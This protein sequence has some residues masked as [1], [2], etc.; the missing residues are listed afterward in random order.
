MR[1]LG[2]DG[3]GIGNN[4]LLTV[5]WVEH[6][7]FPGAA[8]LR[9]VK[10]KV[11]YLAKFHSVTRERRGESNLDIVQADICDE[12]GKVLDV[13]YEDIPTDGNSRFDGE[14]LEDAVVEVMKRKLTE[15]AR[16][17]VIRE[18]D[19]ELVV[20]N[21]ATNFIVATFHYR[22]RV[23]K[24]NPESKATALRRAGI[25]MRGLNG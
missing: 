18:R 12:S 9:P 19:A 1:A 16:P 11:R 2:A 17:F 10:F 23:A 15:V 20:V 6:Y 22:P 25:L 3:L 5:E 4:N 7:K 13:V 8:T 24:D 14:G 21:S